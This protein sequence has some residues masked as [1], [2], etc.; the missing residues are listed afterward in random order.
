MPPRMKRVIAD[1]GHDANRLRAVLREQGTTPV[2]PGRRS[3]K[4][5]I[6]PL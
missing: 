1:R 6:Q 2:I 4:R 3:R 5:P